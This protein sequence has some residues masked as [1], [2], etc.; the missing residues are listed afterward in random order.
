M[1]LEVVLL[2][3]FS[4]EAA[5]DHQVAQVC[6]AEHSPGA[7]ERVAERLVRSLE[8]KRSSPQR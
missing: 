2:P 1:Y 5:G 8:T 6:H 7:H 4:V 3:G